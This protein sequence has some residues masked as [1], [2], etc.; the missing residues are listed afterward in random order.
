[1]PKEKEDS[2]FYRSLAAADG[3][4]DEENRSVRF[5][6][7]SDSPVPMYFGDEVLSHAPG[8]MRTG[9]RQRSMSLL[10]NHDWDRLLGVVDKV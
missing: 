9:E 10:F 8:A 2:L 5:P 3:T 7:V 6:V 4:V 1:M